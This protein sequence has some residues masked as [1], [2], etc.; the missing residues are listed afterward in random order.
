MRAKLLATGSF[1]PSHIVSNDDLAKRFNTSDA[2][3]REKIG[4]RERRY[5]DS[6]TTV[7]DLACQASQIALKHAK[8]SATDLDAIV[9]ATTTPEYVAPGSG[10]LLQNRLGCKNIPAFD[11]RNTSPGFLYS[12]DLADGLICS[13][14]YKRILVVGSEIHSTKLDFSDSGRMMSVIFGDGA[15]AFILEATQGRAGFQDF[16]LHSDG[17]HFDKLWCEPGK[18]PDMDGRFVFENAVKNMGGAVEEILQRNKLQPKDI[19]YFVSHQANLRILEEIQ[20]RF[21]LCDDKLP[22]NIENYGNTSSASIPILMDELSQ[23]G[24]LKSGQKIILMSFG[25]GFCW[26]A[27]L[28]EM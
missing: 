8:L 19:D 10:V 22:H 13:G 23:N 9:F 1:L 24:K 16:V 2:W 21:K 27:S 25:S 17:K 18:A 12:L 14:R 7:T 4:I 11:V 15:G 20:E 6:K 5:A 28:L 26:G 3:I